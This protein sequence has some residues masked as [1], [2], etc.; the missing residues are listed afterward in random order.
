MLSFTHD[1]AYK[2]TELLSATDLPDEAGLRL[3]RRDD[4]TALAMRLV[5]GPEKDDTVIDSEAARVFLDSAAADRVQD[6]VLDATTTETSSA[7]FLRP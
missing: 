7:F 2:I 5:A 1:A 3:A 4:H 6:Q